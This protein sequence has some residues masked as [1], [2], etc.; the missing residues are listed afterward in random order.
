MKLEALTV[1][2]GYADFLAAA[3]PFNLPMFDRY[4]VVTTHEDHA[5]RELCR[6]YGVHVI[7]SEEHKRGG[8]FNKGRLIN[9]G[10]D[11]LSCSDWVMQIDADIVLPQ[12]FRR[13]LTMAH[14]NPKHIYG[15]DRVMV[16]GWRQWLHL[17]DS[18]WLDLQLDYHCRVNFPKHYEIGTR[19]ASALYGYVPIGFLQLW[20]GA[21]TDIYRGVH[22]HHY[23]V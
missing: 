22:L 14:L 10:I 13:A 3:L 19:W 12:T 5:T 9:R 16:H 2:V 6:R 7:L 20:N 21:S 15:V 4:V 17:R 18:G 11:S 8:P 23:P 1:C